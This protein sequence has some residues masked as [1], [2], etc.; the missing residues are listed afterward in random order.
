MRGVAGERAGERGIERS[1]GRARAGEIPRLTGA[2]AL[3][4]GGRCGTVEGETQT[5]PVPV[6]AGG[7][8]AAVRAGPGPV[9][10]APG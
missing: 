5:A 10:R 6:P 3:V 7:P 8:R 4:M 1:S 2:N 9:S